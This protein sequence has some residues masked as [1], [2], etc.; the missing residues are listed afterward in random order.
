LDLSSDPRDIG[1]VGA[2]DCLNVH[3]AYGAVER[4]N[5]TKRYGLN[6]INK[7]TI[8][9]P[10]APVLNIH[11][12][13][14]ASASSPDW[15]LAVVEE[16]PVPILGPSSY[17][18][19]FFNEDV[20]SNWLPLT[21]DFVIS[22]DV[23]AI[24]TFMDLDNQHVL[25]LRQ[26]HRPVAVDSLGTT[27]Q[28]GLEAPTGILDTSNGP[29][30]AIFH[31]TPPVGV[32]NA[33]GYYAS[34]LVADYPTVPFSGEGILPGGANDFPKAYLY[35]F[36]F[37]R[38]NTAHSVLNSES[39]AEFDRLYA[40]LYG[41]YSTD[42]DDPEERLTPLI[43][44]DPG[45]RIIVENDTTI[46][47]VNIYRANATYIDNALPSQWPTLGYHGEQTG[48]FHLAKSMTRE[49]FLAA[50]LIS[51]K[52][53]V[54]DD[55]PDSLLSPAKYA[56]TRNGLPPKAAF[57]TYHQD[58]IIYARVRDGAILEENKG[59]DRVYMSES[60]EW[61][62]V[63]DDDFSTMKIGLDGQPITG[64]Y[65]PY[66]ADCWIT[67]ENAWW[68]IAG[69]IN[70]P[71]NETAGT[72]IDPPIPTYSLVEV[73]NMNGCANLLGC[74][75]MV[76]VDNLLYFA[77]PDGFYAFNGQTFRKISGPI[78]P[79]LK[80][81]PAPGLRRC[82]VGI[83]RENQIIVWSIPKLGSGYPVSGQGPILPPSLA[84]LTNVLAVYHYR[85]VGAEGVGAW[86]IW[87]SDDVS[88]SCVASA[89]TTTVLDQRRDGLLFGTDDGQ[90]CRMLEDA[91][92]DQLSNGTQHPIEWRWR[93]G[94]IDAGIRNRIKHWRS[95]GVD[96]E[97]HSG[98]S[99]TIKV[100]LD[101]I[102]AGYI[103]GSENLS[104]QF[105]HDA[106][107]SNQSAR[108]DMRS[109]LLALEFSGQSTAA[110]KPQ[111]IAGYQLDVEESG[112]R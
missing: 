47:H 54:A 74:K 90:F 93:T 75:S 76:A 95:M 1:A 14:R 41:D 66:F 52:Y 106:T 46:S 22:G 7:S 31:L 10:P 73:S 11:W 70:G 108:I 29:F 96:F 5:G 4:R 28:V 85:D 83:S 32:G 63:A 2:R 111:R 68:Q 6:Q 18:I 77:A 82:T 24:P 84:G 67:K 17:S 37:E 20:D 107:H 51:G 35:A 88:F 110:S 87:A 50:P 30:S 9:N 99:L 39:N 64:I 98:E 33:N 109:E 86:T 12:V 34:R 26:G 43:A 45:Q 21:S 57:A 80:S 105:V 42:Y 92:Y 15:A 59:L 25:V 112:T 3:V 16:E 103:A 36:S 65:T 13:D 27:Y 40:C 94:A 104:V 60:G 19:W 69:F 97:P 56:P 79:L 48:F 78:E 8:P 49:D 101:Q 100:F 55:V 89:M 53:L 23:P 72:G 81:M 38:R 91:G 62:H 71:T 102:A 61:W 58:R 44:F